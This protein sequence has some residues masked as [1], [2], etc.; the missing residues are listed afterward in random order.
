M[1][2]GR[3]GEVNLVGLVLKHRKPKQGKRFSLFN[4]SF[5]FG[6]PTY[7]QDLLEQPPLENKVCNVKEGGASIAMLSGI[8]SSYIKY[9]IQKPRH[10][11]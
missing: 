11:W 5:L 3:I 9:H 10:T 8:R 2:P 4:V 6:N 1:H 7:V